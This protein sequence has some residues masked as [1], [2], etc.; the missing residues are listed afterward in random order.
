MGQLIPF[1]IGVVG[2]L[3]LYQDITMESNG[4]VVNDVVMVRDLETETCSRGLLLKSVRISIILRSQNRSKGERW[5]YRGLYFI[6]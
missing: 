5:N 2:F 6:E 3:K 4:L 1:V